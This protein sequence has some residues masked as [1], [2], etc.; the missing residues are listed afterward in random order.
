M[1]IGWE[2]SR[3]FVVVMFLTHVSPLLSLSSSRQRATQK[4]FDIVILRFYLPPTIPGNDLVSFS[5]LF[6]FLCLFRLISILQLP[7][8]TQLCA[9]GLVLFPCVLRVFGSRGGQVFEGL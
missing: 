4:T 5:E 3:D 7:G 9:W 2:W 1:P 8:K 6:C